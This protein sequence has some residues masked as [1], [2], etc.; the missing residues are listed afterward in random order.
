MRQTTVFACKGAQRTAASGGRAPSSG[1]KLAEPKLVRQAIFP[2]KFLF[3]PTLLSLLHI[4]MCKVRKNLFQQ[5]TN[6]EKIIGRELRIAESDQTEG[7]SYLS[8]ENDFN[9]S[10]LLTSTWR[11]V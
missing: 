8:K 1:S 3:T 10:L 7:F 5:D 9:A 4:E 6:N 11:Q 2:L